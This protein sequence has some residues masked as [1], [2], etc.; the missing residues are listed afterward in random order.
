MQ[1]TSQ[2]DELINYALGEKIEL[3]NKVLVSTNDDK[4][5]SKISLEKVR[6][7]KITKIV[8]DKNEDSLEKL[9]TVLSSVNSAN[10][11]IVYIFRNIPK[12]GLSFYIGVINNLKIADQTL[13]SALQANFAGCEI[14]EESLS[15]SEEKKGSLELKKI[16][17][18]ILNEKY[19][20]SLSTS[21]PSLKNEDNKDSFVQGLEKFLLAM[22]H[23][24]YTAV[25]LAKNVSSFV[26]ERKYG[27]EELYTNLFPLVSNDLILGSN[28]SFSQSDSRTASFSET[29]TKSSSKTHSV[30]KSK[31]KSVQKPSILQKVQMTG[32]PNI[33]AIGAGAAIVGTGGVAAPVVGALG[34][35]LGIGATIGTTKILDKNNTYF[36][37][38]T[39][40]SSTT[41][42]NSETSG[43]SISET[44]S[45]SISKTDSETKGESLQTTLK[46]ENKYLKNQLEII[47]MQL[48]RIK[49]SQNYGMFDFAAYFLAPNIETTITAANIYNS[50]TRGDESYM[51]HSYIQ[52]FKSEDTISIKN[53]L[54][55][56]EHPKFSFS[57]EKISITS[58]INSKELA[59]ALSFPKKSLQ[60]LFVKEC[61]EF[62]RNVNTINKEKN[63]SIGNIYH[64]GKEY[65]EQAI[66]FNLKDLTMHTLITGTTGSGKSTTT[67]KLIDEIKYKNIKFLV[68][69][70]TKGEYKNIFGNQSDVKVYGTNE[71]FTELLKINPFSFPFDKI[72]LL[73][74]ID[75]LVEI[76]NACWPMYSAMPAVMK[77]A[78]LRAYESCG[79]DI[80]ESMCEDL[81]LPTFEDIL[82]QLNI[83]MDN[84]QYSNEIKSNY[85]GALSTRLE[86][87]T[88]GLIGKIFVENE[89][90]DKLLFEENV[91][92]DLSRVGSAETKS[93]IMGILFLK[94]NEYRLSTESMNSDLKHVTILEEAHHLLPRTS[95]EI[96]SESANIKGKAVEMLSNAIAEMRTYGEGFI[97]I[98][99]SPNMLDISAIRNTN[100]KII[101]RLSEIEDRN[102]IGK[103]VALTDEQINEIPKL[104]QGVAI[105]YQ[106]GWDEAVLCKI[107]QSNI[108]KNIEPFKYEKKKKN[109]DAKTIISNLIT[110]IIICKDFKKDEMHEEWFYNNTM[111]QKI[112]DYV[113]KKER[114]T[115]DDAKFV[116]YLIKGKKLYSEIKQQE[117]DF[118]EV[119]KKLIEQKIRI[120]ED[121][122][123]SKEKYLW[124][125]IQLIKIDN[126]NNQDKMIREYEIN[127]DKFY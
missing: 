117:N 38:K 8:F 15:D 47:D 111:K 113:S 62:G 27:Y 25:L 65:K 71:N 33:L 29:V 74:H 93:L 119:V 26:E 19:S 123:I 125:I 49:H 63:I 10:A 6:F 54:A 110:S 23:E 104:S 30:G 90:D 107:I 103:S 57:E 98:D 127:L 13:Y 12:D 86:S 77:D 72:H 97:I 95:K 101:M 60:G 109:Y 20:V 118:T 56:F 59:I 106:N 114:N 51:G 24:E 91:I 7:R 4:L 45:I 3:N 83:I 96:S 112:L 120:Y 116:N 94:L 18:S 5:V 17:E 1:Q 68:I 11:D 69:E 2:N 32:I 124:H 39:K 92:V 108:E 79:W 34:V 87:L 52:S 75:R 43:E 82:E 121:L 100:T 64:L 53:A 37:S 40:S 102:D 73:E 80:D 35:A 48:K 126:S 9:T 61:V 14:S 36:N 46:M 21:I 76:F 67:Y 99:Q 105:V 16:Q 89:I 55:R 31:S 115:K 41:E 122:E 28:V 81:L 84:S 50:L 22:Q 85:K 42:N 44:N 78:I 66:S 88:K 58:M 70:P